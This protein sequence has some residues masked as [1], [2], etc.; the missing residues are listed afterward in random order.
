MGY[1]K[2]LEVGPSKREFYRPKD[3]VLVCTYLLYRVSKTLRQEWGAEPDWYVSIPSGGISNFGPLIVQSFGFESFKTI[4]FN[5][6]FDTVQIIAT[7]GGAFL[8]TR[9][10]MKGP[11]RHLSSFYFG[12]YM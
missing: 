11:G 2:N 12:S 3:L 8:A 9:I 7:M 10:K 6:P 5:I 1:V 4:L